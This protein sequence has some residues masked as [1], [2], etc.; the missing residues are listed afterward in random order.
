MIA[1]N[2]SHDNGLE[3]H[4]RL[5]NVSALA[6]YLS[7]STRQAHR[8]NRNA[9]IPRSLKIGGCTRWREDEISEWLKYG[10]PARSEWEK[11]A[12]QTVGNENA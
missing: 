6:K 8:L 3:G 11:R 12:T 7:I 9:M 2:A 10:A 4:P 1:E 5:L